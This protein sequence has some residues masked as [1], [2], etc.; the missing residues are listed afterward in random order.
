MAASKSTI[1]VV[2]VQE[3]DKVQEHII[4]YLSCDLVGPKLRY[5]HIEKLT[6][7]TCMLFI[8]YV[9]ISY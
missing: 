9:T 5:S 2:P 4:Y 1:G 3:Y 6:L 8:R 7:V